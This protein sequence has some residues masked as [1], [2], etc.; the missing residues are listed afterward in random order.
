MT[1]H[2]CG[3][4]ICSYGRLLI[5][6]FNPAQERDA[7]GRWAAGAS[8]THEGEKYTVTGGGQVSRRGPNKGREP[9]VLK[10]DKT[11]AM[12]IAYADEL[13]GSSGTA[14]PAKTAPLA[15]VV[16]TLPS[17]PK[18]ELGRKIEDYAKAESAHIGGLSAE[19]VGHAMKVPAAKAKEAIAEKLGGTETKIM[20]SLAKE[21]ARQ[22]N[23]M[24]AGKGL[25]KVEYELKHLPLS[26]VTPSQHG[27]DYKNDSST[28]LSKHIGTFGSSGRFA[29]YAPIAVD[30]KGVI[31]DGNHRH[32]AR[33]MAGIDT[34]PVLVLKGAKL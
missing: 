22:A 11:G 5:N 25:P 26:S 14:T 19:E 1:R 4:S 29:D 18:S 31:T 12:K 32:A 24:R 28:G 2:L 9:V 23:D 6:S 21:Q 20:K 17:A 10:H 34:I 3:C 8:V 16:K 30:E 13:K 27:E 15:A 33:L 7:N